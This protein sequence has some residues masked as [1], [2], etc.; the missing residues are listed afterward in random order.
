[1][2]AISPA[3]GSSAVSA[4]SL[5]AS[6]P[7]VPSRDDLVALAAEPDPAAAGWTRAGRALQK[8]GYRPTG[9]VFPQIT[10]P[11]ANYNVAGQR[12]VVGILNDP[13]SSVV[14]R[15]KRWHK[16]RL[17][18]IEVTA[19]DGRKLGFNWDVALG[20]YRFDGFREP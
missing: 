1:L 10:G 5:G 16:Q 18:F 2:V 13:R 20:R 19:P 4:G 8:H 15:S 6:F 9:S 11:P 3:G 17:P 12:I 7:P 14:L